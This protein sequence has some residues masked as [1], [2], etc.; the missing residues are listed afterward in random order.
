MICTTPRGGAR[1]EALLALPLK[2]L[3]AAG[4]RT[5]LDFLKLFQTSP[6]VIQS[7][8]SSRGKKN[9]WCPKKRK[10]PWLYQ[11]SCSSYSVCHRSS[12]WP[13]S[14]IYFP[15][16]CFQSFHR[17]QTVQDTCPF[18]CHDCYHHY[19]PFTYSSLSSKTYHIY[20]QYGE[21]PVR[22]GGPTKTS[23]QASR[24]GKVS[25]YSTNQI[26]SK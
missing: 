25:T 13:I 26:C 4:F 1:T 3:S 17:E 23:T 18:P 7:V 11:V 24:T 9:Q 14:D 12:W 8:T 16:F 15:A 6:Q 5:P 21:R 10:E 2:V 19:K 20:T 22:H